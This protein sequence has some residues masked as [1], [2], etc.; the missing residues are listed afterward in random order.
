MSS[1]AREL[2]QGA[3]DLHYHSAPSPFPRKLDP[4]EAARHYDQAGFRA[5]VL[6]SHHHNTQMDVLAL[7]STVLSHLKVKVYGGIALNGT[8]GGVNP[9]AVELSLRMGGKI[10]W[11]PTIS[12]PAHIEYHSHGGGFPEPT[13]KLMPEAP[14]PVLG[15]DG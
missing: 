12:S 3:V 4:A 14:N 13:M 2:L 15:D 9:R 11:F 7:E 8:V 1:T 10:V 6:K 5:V